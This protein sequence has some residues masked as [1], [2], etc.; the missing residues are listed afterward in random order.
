MKPQK[1]IY[2]ESFEQNAQAKIIHDKL[3]DFILDI[4]DF[5]KIINLYN[6]VFTLQLQAHKNYFTP[7]IRNIVNKFGSVDKLL[8][9]IFLEVRLLMQKNR[10][11]DDII[12]HNDHLHKT[13]LNK[14]KFLLS[15]YF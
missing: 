6:I 14:I 5:K 7:D 1:G 12:F 2:P 10:I 9:S 4:N 8:K 13:T 15:G 3:L 11:R